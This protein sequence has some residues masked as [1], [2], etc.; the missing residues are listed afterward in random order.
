MGS[1]PLYLPD[2]SDAMAN[3]EARREF[4]QALNQWIELGN[5]LKAFVDQHVGFAGGP[6]PKPMTE[7]ALKEYSA[8]HDA[9]EAAHQRYLKAARAHLSGSYAP[10]S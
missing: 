7:E 10:G 9:T 2:R 3:E 5:K 8:L 6:Q 1:G 4:I